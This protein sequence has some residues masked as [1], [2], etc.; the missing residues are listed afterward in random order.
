MSSTLPAG[1]N[2]NECMMLLAAL[3]KRR[4]HKRLGSSLPSEFFP[5]DLV[6][7]RQAIDS[8]WETNP[9]SGLAGVQTIGILARRLAGKKWRTLEGL[10]QSFA[11]TPLPEDDP[12][13]DDLVSS[14]VQRERF[15]SLAL[16]IAEQC[17]QDALEPVDIKRSVEEIARL[18]TN[19]AWNIVQY[20][21]STDTDLTVL[22]RGRIPIG[23]EIIDHALG[24]G[25]GPGEYGL[26]IAPYRGGKS[27][28]LV[29]FGAQGVLLGKRVLH[30]SLEMS[31]ALVQMRYDMRFGAVTTQ[32][33]LR[34]QKRRVREIRN[35][36][37][38][39]GGKLMILDHS[40]R[41]MTPS[42][43]E[44]VIEQTGPY[45]LV[46]LDY[47]KPMRSDRKLEGRFEIED[48]TLELR[49]I[50]SFYHIPIWCAAQTNREGVG[51]RG[52][53]SGAHV[54]E[55]ISQV[56]TGDVVILARQSDADK[57]LSRMVLVLDKT[58]MS[59]DID[60]DPVLVRM[61]YRTMTLSALK[62]SEEEEQDVATDHSRE[63]GRAWAKNQGGPTEARFE[64]P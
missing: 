56:Q 58:R 43:L 10:W 25:L 44:R 61:D 11:Q 7:L 12:V 3:R 29:N 59:L 1:R 33:L 54:G 50:A 55:D 52:D 64:S 35:R 6:Y 19:G 38:D 57:A 53:F 4:L 26:V 16:R 36:V 9:D 23:I 15:R 49:R 51:Q 28:V 32:E 37:V 21:S 31:R 8:Y 47:I 18:S 62:L 27:A 22:T 2:L 39:T 5:G 30:V 13:L 63:A 46:I 40:H 20:D 24:G 42:T 48:V 41:K 60:V 14:Y 45:D 34:M 17:D